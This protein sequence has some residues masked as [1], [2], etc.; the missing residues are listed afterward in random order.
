MDNGYTT[1]DIYLA[2]FLLLNDAN[3]LKLIPKDGVIWFCF[4][5]SAKVS[6]LTQEYFQRSG[7]V[8]PL[9]YIETVKTLRHRVR[10]TLKR[11]RW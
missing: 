11:G 8:E 9:T 6:Q 7:K 2:S 4:E 3:L 5:E 10:D 1:R